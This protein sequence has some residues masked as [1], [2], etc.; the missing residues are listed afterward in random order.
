MMYRILVIEDEP[1]ISMMLEDELTDRGFCVAGLAASVQEG[2]HLLP[3]V[4]PHAAIVD[5]QLLDGNCF[6]LTA[7]LTRRHIPFVLLTGALLDFA[8][9]RFAHMEV[10]S[11]PVDLDRLTAV[12]ARLVSRTFKMPRSPGLQGSHPA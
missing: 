10:M 12:L 7:E 6:D 3:Q 1:L 4:H 2:L 8:D 11:K 5:F 9:A